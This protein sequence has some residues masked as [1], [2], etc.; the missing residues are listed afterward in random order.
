MNDLVDVA[1]RVAGS[2]RRPHA[3]ARADLKHRSVHRLHTQRRAGFALTRSRRSRIATDGVREG[4]RRSGNP[5]DNTS[6]QRWHAPKHL[7]VD[8]EAALHVVLHHALVRAVDIRGL[9]DLDVSAEPVMG[10]EI[11][12]VL[13]LLQVADAPPS[14]AV[15]SLACSA[16]PTPTQRG[17]SPLPQRVPPL[18]FT[19]GTCLR[20]FGY[21]AHSRK[22]RFNPGAREPEIA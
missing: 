19:P 22:Y 13:G 17:V 5:Q 16:W 7:R 1:W 2:I 11:E 10:A 21:P 6:R 14:A 12:H 18:P 20:T 4:A 9:D 3:G 15:S 8:D